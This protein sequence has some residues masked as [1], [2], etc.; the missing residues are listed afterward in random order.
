VCLGAGIT[1]PGNEKVVTTVEQNLMKGPVVQGR[2]WVTHRNISYLFLNKD[3][4]S[5]GASH[6]V[7]KW[8]WASPSLSDKEV[9]ADVFEL[10]IC[11]TNPVI[12]QS[13]SYAILP[14]VSFF[15]KTARYPGIK[16]IENSSDRQSVSISGTTMTVLWEPFG[17]QISE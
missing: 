7:G 6:H 17:L 9:G 3:D 4:F 11:H 10:L 16:I 15:H 2:N 8:N 13:Y 5:L 12:N 1:K 14:G